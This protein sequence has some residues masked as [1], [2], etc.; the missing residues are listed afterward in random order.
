ML[1]EAR[2]IEKSSRDSDSGVKESTPILEWKLMRWSRHHGA[3]SKLVN[4]L[5]FKPK[6]HY[7]LGERILKSAQ[8]TPFFEAIKKPRGIHVF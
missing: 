1:G 3:Y 2:D 5:I 8:I 4:M 6:N 7:F